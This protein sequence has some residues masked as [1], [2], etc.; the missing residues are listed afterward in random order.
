M[1]LVNIAFHIGHNDSTPIGAAYLWAQQA[2]RPILLTQCGKTYVLLYT[3]RGKTYSISQL[4]SLKKCN[5]EIHLML[6]GAILY[7]TP[8]I[9][10]ST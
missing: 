5:W 6:L 4:E 1:L 2:K 7:T 3:D 8:Y 10:I 9:G